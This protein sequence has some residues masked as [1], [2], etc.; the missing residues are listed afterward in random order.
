[1]NRTTSDTRNTRPSP[2][3]ENL[4]TIR[5]RPRNTY[6]NR[7]TPNGQLPHSKQALTER[8]DHGRGSRGGDPAKS[9]SGQ[10]RDVVND[11]FLSPDAM[12]ESLTSSDHPDADHQPH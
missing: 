1:M 8:G 4:R 7:G 6:A 3:G 5:T 12:N 9:A 2:A 11:S 10:V